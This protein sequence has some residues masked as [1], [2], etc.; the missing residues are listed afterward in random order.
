M[1]RQRCLGVPKGRGLA[2]KGNRELKLRREVLIRDRGFQGEIF[3]IL[4]RMVRCHKKTEL[5]RPV[6]CCFFP[7]RSSHTHLP[8]SIGLNQVG[9]PCTVAFPRVPAASSA[10]RQSG[11]LCGLL[12]GPLP[13]SPA[14]SDTGERTWAT[15]NTGLAPFDWR[16]PEIC[17]WKDS[18]QSWSS[19][20]KKQLSRLCYRHHT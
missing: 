14:F 8:Q 5:P 18:H 6:S 7:L 12:L 11:R 20:E 19:L 17:D 10:M 16:R 2:G 13:C 15:P 4:F 9:L 3:M 1:L